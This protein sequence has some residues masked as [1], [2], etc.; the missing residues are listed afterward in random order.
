[1][2][3]IVANESLHRGLIVQGIH[4]HIQSD[5]FQ[6]WSEDLNNGFETV[7]EL[8]QHA[9]AIL[10]YYHS[11][12]NALAVDWD[13]ETSSFVWLLEKNNGHKKMER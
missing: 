7:D 2:T 10:K 12:L 3:H 9:N 8:V 5:F 13:D 1:M 11:P 6:M 4:R